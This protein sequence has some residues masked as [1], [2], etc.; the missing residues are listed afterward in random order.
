MQ[1]S[2]QIGCGLFKRRQAHSDKAE[3]DRNI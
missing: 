2:Q 1:K 3:T